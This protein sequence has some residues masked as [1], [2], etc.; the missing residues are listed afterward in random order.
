MGSTSPARPRSM[1]RRFVIMEST[2]STGSPPRSAG[3]SESAEP[4]GALVGALDDWA[5]NTADSA[6]RGRLLAVADAA[7]G[8]PGSFNSQVRTA[9]ARGEKLALTKLAEEAPSAK[10]RP[11]TLVSLAAGL[12]EQGELAQAVELLRT[13]QEHQPGDFWL[14]LELATTLLLWKPGEPREALPFV[15]AALARATGTPG[16]MPTLVT[17]RSRPGSWPTP[18]GRSVRPFASRETSRWQLPISAWCSTSRAS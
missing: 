9:L 17:P 12:R 13:A 1:Q 8:Q 7:E 4:R 18:R 5:L 11:A 16:S 15:T 6:A 14:N 3:R 10:R 2:S